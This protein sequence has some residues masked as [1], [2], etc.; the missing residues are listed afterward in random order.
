MYTDGACQGNPGPGGWAW[1]VPGGRWRS[2]AE[3]RSTNQRME[4]NAALDA[5]RTLDGPLEIVS[6]STY[7]VNCFQK[8]WWR[9]WVVNGWVSTSRQP[10]AN[11][12]L[13]EPLVDIYR[14]EPGRIRFRWVKGHSTDPYNDLVD[15]LAVAAA[16]SQMGGEGDAPPGVVEL[17]AADAPTRVGRSRAGV[18]AEH[19][20]AGG[21]PG[22]RS[23]GAEPTGAEPTGAE[24]FGAL[25]A[26][27]AGVVLR[28]ARSDDEAALLE[29]CESAGLPVGRSER[30]RLHELISRQPGALLVAERARPGPTTEAAPV[31]G[32]AVVVFDGW[33]GNVYVLAVHPASRGSGVAVLL[34][35]EA[36][37]R[38][39]SEGARQIAVFVP[40][41]GVVSGGPWEVAGYRRVGDEV[42]VKDF[43]A[44]RGAPGTE[45]P[46]GARV[47]WV[48]SDAGPGMQ[49][50]AED[51]LQAADPAGGP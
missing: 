20:T 7:V 27:E 13:W 9:K 8:D 12:D 16:S 15:R 19:G 50:G 21:R 3:R 49:K 5:A 47:R 43:A 46:P 44:G 17:G 31:A 6:D 18:V 51:R 29:L 26:D 42:Y 48:A 34:V 2:G 41:G 32:A 10:V 30:L 28:Q 11:R 39:A 14:S 33:R 38:L 4:I 1:A 23:P 24:L 22:L 25:G 36:E 45:R 37:R 40:G 35:E